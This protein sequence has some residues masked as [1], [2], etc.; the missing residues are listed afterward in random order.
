M[1]ELVGT[2]NKQTH[3]L[4]SG[5]LIEG[6]Y[7]M[8]DRLRE[9][10]AIE[11]ESYVAGLSNS[12]PDCHGICEARVPWS[13]D[14]V[15]FRKSEA[16]RLII[17][18]GRL[19]LARAWFLTTGPAWAQPLPLGDSEWMPLMQRRGA[20]YL[21]GAYACSLQYSN[22]DYLEHPSFHAFGCGVMA[23]P[24][25]PDHVRDD[26]E[27]QAEFPAQPL[28]GLCDRLTWFGE[29]VPTDRLIS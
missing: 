20:M 26:P 25:A 5:C 21:L 9:R 6:H 16:P 11:F 15:Q 12:V 10:C 22:Y 28:P 3:I 24:H 27:L 18:V 13:Y 8:S 23:H 4:C 7:P 29:R 19:L 17:E 2:N 14:K 1:G